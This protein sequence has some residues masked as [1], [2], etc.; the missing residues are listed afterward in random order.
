M[1]GP[2]DR[3]VRGRGIVMMD[4][5]GWAVLERR[6][7]GVRD[8]M[9]Q[10]LALRVHRALSW[11]GRAE[12]ERED[13]DARF[14]FLWIALNAAY[15]QVLPDTFRLAETRLLYRFLERLQRHDRERL[16]YGIVWDE[17]SGP[18]RLLLENP[19][20]FRPFWD[21]QRGRI[22]Q[23]EWERR[24]RRSRAAALRALGRMDTTR[25][26]ME[27][28]E[29]LYVLRNQLFH[30]NA[31]WNGRRNREPIEQGAQVLGRLVP[32]ILSILL[33]CRGQGWGE[34]RYPPVIAVRE[35]PAQGRA[36][37]V[38]QGP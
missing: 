28:F 13:P 24:F 36:R 12:R 3:I 2:E 18:I 26:L 27:I 37:C 34:A 17:F 38:P 25:V 21:W 1:L 10:G 20:V 23:G 30:G 11:L 7:L 29:R 35:A 32:A 15:A 5:A 31:T 6:Y 9:P 16:L 4:V 8:R 19:Y 14:I 33:E 22:T